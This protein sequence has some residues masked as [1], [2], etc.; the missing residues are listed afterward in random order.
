MEKKKPDIELR[1]LCWSVLSILFWEASFHLLARETGL[2]ADF[3]SR[4]KYT[5]FLRFI[6]A[7]TICLVAYRFSAIALIG[8]SNKDL[9][10]GARSGCIYSLAIGVIVFIV[11][12]V[13]WLSGIK[14]LDY[15]RIDSVK[16]PLDVFWFFA[17]GGLSGPIAEEIFFRGVLFGYFKRMG[18]LAATLISTLMFVLMHPGAGLPVTQ[19]L[20]GLVFC[21]SYY[22]SGSLLTPIIIHVS[23][24]LAIFALGIFASHNP[25]LF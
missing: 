5:F 20:G 9:M 8:L 13:F 6:E 7:A 19:S 3:S 24:N 18:F 1:L 21:W 17:A 23:G 12:F 15:F 11:M 22:R 4:M 25:G 10:K 14:F 16:K 2:V